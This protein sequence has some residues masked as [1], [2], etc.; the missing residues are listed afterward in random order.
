MLLNEGSETCILIEVG[1]RVLTRPF[2]RAL[3]VLFFGALIP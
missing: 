2:P 1:N 3:T